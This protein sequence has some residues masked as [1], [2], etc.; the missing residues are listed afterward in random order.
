MRTLTNYE[1][2]SLIVSLLFVKDLIY[3]YL[4]YLTIFT[5][6]EIQDK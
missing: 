3:T 2:T 4:I 6:I 5:F 1:S